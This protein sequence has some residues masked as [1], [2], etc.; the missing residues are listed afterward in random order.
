MKI[1][2]LARSL[3][4]GGAERQLVLLAAGLHER[5]HVVSVA[6]FYGRGEF[7]ADLA[8]AGI[9]H[10][11]LEKRGRWDLFGFMARLRRCVQ[12]EQP[13]I[14]HSYLPMA[15]IV[16]ALAPR[17]GRKRP[18]IVWGI[19]ASD[20]RLARYDWLEGLSYLVEARLSG[21]ADCIIANAKRGL[22][23]AIARG[24]RQDHAVVIPNGIDEERFRP[25][26]AAR[27]EQRRQLGVAEPAVLVGMPARFD[28]M[29]D[30]GN[31]LEAARRLSGRMPD[32]SFVLIGEGTAPG[33]LMLDRLV[34]AAGLTSPL[35]RLGSRVDMPEMYAAL[36]I[37]C[38]SS[39]FGE[40]FPNVLGEAMA[41]GVPCVA[42]DVG[43]AAEIIGDTGEVVSSGDSTALADGLERMIHRL[44]AEPD[45]VRG[46]ARRRIVT[47]YGRERLIDRTERVLTAVVAGEPIISTER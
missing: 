13:D 42:T 8:E 32:V 2:F 44:R 4:P 3:G 39:A 33:N 45:V 38:L 5:G 23:A 17:S 35:L 24:A 43:D 10:I 29:K 6:T 37:V 22:D 21:I 16:T 18:R 30:H 25:D 46:A 36:D 1:L 7:A 15:N 14:V 19:R 26:A 28:A 31:F 47:H 12:A 27:W 40:G 34:Q 20:V 11:S 9:R 41:A